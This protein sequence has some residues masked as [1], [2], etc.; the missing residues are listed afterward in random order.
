MEVAALA[1]GC[2][3]ITLSAISVGWQMFTWR[4]ERRFDVRLTVEQDGVGVGG[5]RYPVR[6]VATNHG[7]TTEWINRLWIDA[8]YDRVVNRKLTFYAPELVQN[9]RRD[10][11]LPPRQRFESE[12]N[13]LSGLIGGGGLPK[14]I[15]ARAKFASGREV[16]SAAF[17]PQES[18][19]ATALEPPLEGLELPGGATADY[20]PKGP[21][22][23]CPDCKSEIPS[24][25]R[26]CAACGF[27][28]ERKTA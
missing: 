12:Y 1:V 15:V 4:R 27:Q 25:A 28:F 8:T 26:V 20:F 14:E 21:E 3:A 11:E 23:I 19:A 7:G 9:P 24:D 10:R 16:S 22:V 6:V 13:L 17:Q 5:R 2:V 18:L